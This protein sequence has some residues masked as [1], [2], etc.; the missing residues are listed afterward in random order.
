M[1]EISEIYD[2]TY[3]NTSAFHIINKQMMNQKKLNEGIAEADSKRVR[4]SGK[5]P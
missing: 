3:I 5:K 2:P 1:N 4:E